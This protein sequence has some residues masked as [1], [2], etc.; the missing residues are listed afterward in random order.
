MCNSFADQY[1]ENKRKR[2]R[3]G[4]DEDQPEMQAISEDLMVGGGKILIPPD[5]PS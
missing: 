4:A 1:I 5:N 3:S 2:K